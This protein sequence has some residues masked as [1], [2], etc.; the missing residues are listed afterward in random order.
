MSQVIAYPNSRTL[1]AGHGLVA[2][3]AKMIADYRLYYATVEELR[4]LSDRDLADLG[5]HRSSIKDIA[6]ES[7]YGA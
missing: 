4:Q 7:V 2:R 1:D 3:I 6:R 5:L